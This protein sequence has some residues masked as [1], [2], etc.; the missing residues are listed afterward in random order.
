MDVLTNLENFCKHSEIDL[1]DV[2]DLKKLS[3]NHDRKIKGFYLEMTTGT[4]GN[5][6]PILKDKKTRL[7]EKIYL[8]KIRHNR[9][10]RSIL[11]NGYFFLHPS[12]EI[13]KK[14]NENKFTFNGIKKI[15]E[16]LI[17]KKIE[18]IWTEP[19]KVEF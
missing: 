15:S 9:M 7:L 6:F 11:K 10:G 12:D 8:N 14:M 18:W 4:T 17:E 13:Q 5:P 16:Y 19:Y 2:L 3:L 1:E